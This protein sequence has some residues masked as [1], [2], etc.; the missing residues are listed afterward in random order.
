[1][2]FEDLQQASRELELIIF[3]ILELQPHQNDNKSKIS[4][5]ACEISIEHSISI[6]DLI[7][8]SRVTS[9]ISLLRLQFESLVRAYWVYNAASDTD[10]NKL[11]ADLD[12]ITAKSADGLPMLSEMITKLD[13]KIGNATYG[14]LQEFKHYSWKV[15]SSYVH[16]GLHAV[17]RNEKGFPLELVINIIKQSNGLMIMA[18]MLVAQI[19]NN[20]YAAQ[21]I[22][23]LQD[24]FSLALPDKK[25]QS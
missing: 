11:A 25:S 6:K 13:G 10:T 22:I 12:P 20:Y 5:I 18:S 17:S 9:A 19:A 23:K 15:T 8:L 3:Q 14:M 24:D 4:K 7:Y 16:C 2:K 1:M 21:H